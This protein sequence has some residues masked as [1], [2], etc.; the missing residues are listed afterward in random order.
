M[1]TPPTDRSGAGN[2]SVP[3]PERLR[4]RRGDRFRRPRGGRRE[5]VPQA[6]G[7]LPR[8]APVERTAIRESGEHRL[9]RR[10]RR[11]GREAAS[12][13]VYDPWVLG[14]ADRIP[15][16]A[17]LAHQRDRVRDRLTAASAEA[18]E[19]AALAESRLHADVTAAGERLLRAHERREQLTAQLVNTTAQLDRLARRADRWQA[20]RD[21]VAGRYERRRRRAALLGGGGD[22]TGSGVQ[23]RG[24]PGGG[25]TDWERVADSDPA[26]GSPG[27]GAAAGSGATQ[28]VWEGARTRPGISRTG[29][30]AVLLLLA[31][32]ELPV[33]YVVFQRLHGGGRLEQVLSVS[34]TFAV[35]TVMILAPHYA[36]RILRGRSATGAIRLAALPALV[37]VAAWGYGAWMLGL[38]RARLIFADPPTRMI[39]GRTYTPR[40]AIHSL[41]LDET[42]V[43]VMFIALLLLS[44]GIAF[45]IGL[46]DEHP[47]LGS[48]RD[49]VAR[50]AALERE[51]AAGELERERARE[52]V[53]SLAARRAERRAAQEARLHGVGS[54][55]ESA[56]AAYLDGVAG[57]AGDPA[58]TEAAA[59][60]ARQWPLL[61]AAPAASAGRASLPGPAPAPEGAGAVRG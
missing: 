41:E 37:L 24:D 30:I 39:N 55:Y 54:L 11:A 34:L 27:T 56:A 28:A 53:E 2:G 18:E 9:V 22:G 43:A 5:Q 57:S 58:V 26:A 23:G 31:L 59:R 16:F 8:P 38:M 19:D 29:R 47:Y 35:S 7:A 42:T 32:V 60:L 33:Y 3:L 44:G 20:F 1:S 17:E 61:P 15:Y 51:I 50:R 6:G 12:R 13:G 48:Y 45:L 21:S 14:S 46:G 25:G 40:S 4:A 36:A 10:A 49:L 52:A